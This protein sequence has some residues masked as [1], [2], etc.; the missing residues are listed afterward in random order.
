MHFGRLF[1]AARV[2]L[3]GVALAI[4]G[5]FLSAAPQVVG[6][7]P[8]SDRHEVPNARVPQVSTGSIVPGS[9][10]PPVKIHF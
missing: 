8:R 6:G 4:G 1:F 7:I 3:V 10:P 2:S 9:V 5:S